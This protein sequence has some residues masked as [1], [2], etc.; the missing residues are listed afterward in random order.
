MPGLMYPAYQKF[1]AAICSLMRFKKENDF[2]DNIASMDNFFSEYRSTT[3]VMQKSLSKTPYE[4]IYKQKS[5]GIWDKFFNEQRV[6]TI[7]QHPFEFTKTIQITIYF[8]YGG[9]NISSETFTVENDV[10]LITLENRLKEFFHSFKDNETF[11]S[12]NY[13]FKEKESDDDLW[14]MLM[15]GI[16]TLQIFMDYMYKTI[17]ENCP[18]CDKLREEIN[19]AGFALIPRDFFLINDYVYYLSNEEFERAGRMAIVFSGM[20]RQSLK[21]FMNSPIYKSGNT[22]FENFVMMHVVMQSTELMPVLMTVYQ[23]ET[24]ELDVFHADIKTTIYRKI[25]ETAKKVLKGDAKE[26]FFMNTYIFCEDNET[27]LKATSKERSKM[28]QNEV[29][30][31]MKVDQEMNEEEYVFEG[32]LLNN[33]EY[34][35]KHMEIGKREKL[36]IGEINLVPIKEA[37]KLLKE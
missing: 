13:F 11:F 6:K 26:V 4:E 28:S 23:D 20:N 3:L 31:F 34:I 16:N 29:L 19:K 27:N 15:S 12:A 25:N 30:A 1:Y 33:I 35:A 7:H 37:F 21:G 17:N 9:R 5:E 22:V 8:P 24:F 14:D 36:E 10:P 18:L 2:F 32:Q